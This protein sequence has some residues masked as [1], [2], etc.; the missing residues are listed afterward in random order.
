MINFIKRLLGRISA[1]WQP[2]QRDDPDLELVF[3][4]SAP[5]YGI[6]LDELDLDLMVQGAGYPAAKQSFGR[7]G[8]KMAGTTFPRGIGTHAYGEIWIDLKYNVKRFIAMAGIDDETAGKGS[9]HFQVWADGRQLLVTPTVYGGHDPVKV[10]VDVSGCRYLTLLTME[11]PSGLD[12]AH[13]NWG[14]ALL[15]LKNEN[16]AKPEVCG[17]KNDDPAPT[18][19]SGASLKPRINGARV[20]GATPGKPFLFRVPATGQAPLTFAAQNLPAGLTLDSVTGI[21]S[22]TLTSNGTTVATLIVSNSVCTVA[23]EL[24]IVAEPD[25]LALTPPMGWNSWN[26]WGASVDAE[27]VKAAADRLVSTGLAAHGYQYV[28]IDD[29]WEGERDANGEITPNEKFGDMKALADYVHS[30]GLK[31]GIYSSPGPKTCQKFEGS[32]GH[33]AQDAAT[34]ANWGIDFLKYDLCSLKHMIDRN[35]VDQLR[36]PYALMGRILKD[37]PRDIV[38]SLCQYGWGKVWQWGASVRGNLWRTTRDIG[39]TWRSVTELGFGS[40]GNEK[41]AGPGHWNDP[42]MLVV[43]VLGRGFWDGPIRNTR[44]SKHEQL[45]HITMWSLL[46]APLL[47]GCDLDRLDDWTRDLLSNDEVIDINQDPLGKQATRL[48]KKGLYEVWGKELSDGTYALGI[49][50]RSIHANRIWISWDDLKIGLQ[51]RLPVRDLWQQKDLG[52]FSSEFSAYVPAHSCA[53]IRVGKIKN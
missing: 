45:S 47:I 51:G 9:A 41:F 11:G 34:F 22:G 17:I 37:I 24:K 10:D 4:D 23:R 48:W 52:L 16:S 26:V 12:F 21:I 8:I 18:I 20:V 13:A 44:L 5:S 7:N 38:Y 39:D 14:G 30:L 49:F 31:L 36:A 6:W 15:L 28:N 53:L 2:P 42:D 32:Y 25:S 43:G 27:K 40:A 35:E 3:A 19:A 46:S 50:N 1:L 33:E 29:G